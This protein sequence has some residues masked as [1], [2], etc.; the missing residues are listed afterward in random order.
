MECDDDFIHGTE[1]LSFSGSPFTFFGK[2]I[3]PQYHILG[4]RR[5]RFPVGRR[6]DIV[7]GKHKHA[8][9]DLS[10]QGKRKMD[11]H[12]VPVEVSV[13]SRT[14]EGMDL[15]GFSFYQLRHKGLDAETVKGRCTVQEN[16]M[17]FDDLIQVL[18]DFRRGLFQDLPGSLEGIYHIFFDPVEQEGFEEFDG[19][20]FGDPALVQAKLGVHDDD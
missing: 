3:E 20:L 12:L 2:V 9:F 19:H 1:D 10:F 7:F 6:K 16:R 11:T 15:D 8:G 18:P 13:K 17:V 5:Q 4:R 14:D